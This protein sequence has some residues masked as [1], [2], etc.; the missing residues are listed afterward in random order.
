M[1]ESISRITSERGHAEACDQLVDDRRRAGREPPAR[2]VCAEVLSKREK[3]RRRIVFGIE[4]YC[5]QT[6]RLYADLTLHVSELT[7][8]QRTLVDIAARGEEKRDDD[9][10]PT[11]VGK[12]ERAPVLIDE[13]QRRHRIP[14]L[15]RRNESVQ[16]KTEQQQCDHQVRKPGA[17]YECA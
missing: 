3:P 11:Q 12:T 5:D 7:R 6:N 14:G 13:R 10:V 17:R 4:R 9:D 8:E 1:H 2:G 16:R 15:E